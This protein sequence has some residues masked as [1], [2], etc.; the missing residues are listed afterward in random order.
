MKKILSILLLIACVL[1][2]CEKEE[3]VLYNTQITPDLSNPIIQKLTNITWYREGG[4]SSVREEWTSLLNIPKPSEA[5]ASL[6]FSMAWAN[7]TLHRDGTS[8]MLYIPPLFP[9]TY[10]H[11]QGTWTVSE[12]EENTIVVNTKTPVS[13][14]IV[15]IKVLNLEIQDNVAALNVSMD[16]GNRLMSVFLTNSTFDSRSDLFDEAWYSNNVVSTTPVKTEDFIGGWS[17]AQYD[18][19]KTPNSKYPNESIIRS[20]HVDDLFAQTPNIFGGVK[21]I[22]QNDGK[23]YINYSKEYQKGFEMNEIISSDARWFIK[24]NKVVL[25]CD[26]EFF[27]SAGQ[28]L[29]GFPTNAPNLTYY[30]TL[31]DTPITSQ[32]KRFYVFEVIKREQLGMW[33]RITTNDANAYAFLF[34]TDAELDNVV[35]IKDLIK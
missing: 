6:L 16:F 34:T 15:K 30:G 31:K 1:S 24:G 12:N 9:E 25:E 22:F 7:I 18:R 32:S 5:M 33:C 2:S 28:L 27:Y 20:K 4:I 26:E 17:T 8:S 23:A 21:F 3:T 10:I 14:G 35:N 13:S 19:V 11:C 29:F